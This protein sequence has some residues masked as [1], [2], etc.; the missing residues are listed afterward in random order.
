MKLWFP[1]GI[2]DAWHFVIVLTECIIL[3]SYT[4]AIRNLNW[5]LCEIKVNGELEKL[6]CKDD[7]LRRER[8]LVYTD[9]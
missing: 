8:Y 3:T 2:Q 9:R 6:I 5:K 7:D 4:D 1:S